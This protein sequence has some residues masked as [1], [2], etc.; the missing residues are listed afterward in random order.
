[1][2]PNCDKSAPGVS[3]PL[4]SLDSSPGSAP[5]APTSS[6]SLDEQFTSL[7]L[8]PPLVPFP[9]AA[10]R[11]LGLHYCCLCFGSFLLSG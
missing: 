1:M 10:I 9:K 2:V 5:P 11:V 7:H 6:Q 8:R 3:R 4:A